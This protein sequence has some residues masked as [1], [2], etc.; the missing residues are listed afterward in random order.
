MIDLKTLLEESDSDDDI[1]SDFLIGE[2]EKTVIK[3]EKNHTKIYDKRWCSGTGN[4]RYEEN[5]A[6]NA[7]KRMSVW[8]Y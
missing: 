3:A 2:N 1:D 7:L 6:I 8:S 5:Y 4:D